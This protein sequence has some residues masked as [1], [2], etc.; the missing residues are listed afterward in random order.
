MRLGSQVSAGTTLLNTI[1]TREP[2]LA[3][4]F[5]GDGDGHSALHWL[6]SKKGRECGRLHAALR[7]ARRPA[8]RRAR[9]HP[10]HRPRR[11]RRKPAP[12]R[13][14][15]RLPT[16]SASLKA[17]LSGVLKVLNTALGQPLWSSPNRAIVEQMGENFVY[18]APDDSAKQR[19][20][21]LGPRLRD[22]IVI[23]KRHRSRR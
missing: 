3:V 18:V 15:W 20:V 10:D 5:A 2:R 7:A 8:L 13:C 19:K 12:S 23:L 11:E 9:P 14:G 22:E 17:G 1:S 6:C 4:D 16:P 21:Q